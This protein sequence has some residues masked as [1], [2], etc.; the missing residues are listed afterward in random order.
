MTICN[1]RLPLPAKLFFSKKNIIVKKTFLIMLTILNLSKILRINER[2]FCVTDIFFSNLH[3]S[4]IL[5]SRVFVSNIKNSKN[6]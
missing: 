6:V 4:H 2:F 3:S 1:W 5:S